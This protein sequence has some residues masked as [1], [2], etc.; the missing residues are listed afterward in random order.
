MHC[1]LMYS[2]NVTVRR[3]SIMTF[4]YNTTVFCEN[5]SLTVD[6]SVNVW[7]YQCRTPLS[8]LHVSSVNNLVCFFCLSVWCSV[9]HDE[10]TN[11]WLATLSQRWYFLPKVMCKE[12]FPYFCKQLSKLSELSE[13]SEL[14]AVHVHSWYQSMTIGYLRVNPSLMGYL[15]S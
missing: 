12:P 13:L 5:T 10:P 4:L 8:F 3:A 6:V 14:S 7:I 2:Y 9:R 15:F 11:C 1:T